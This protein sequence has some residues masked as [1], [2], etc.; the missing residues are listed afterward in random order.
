MAL[1]LGGFI[2]KDFIKFFFYPFNHPC[3]L[4]APQHSPQR[5]VVEGAAESDIRWDRIKDLRPVV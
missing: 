3:Q 5:I 2:F 4:L 1:A